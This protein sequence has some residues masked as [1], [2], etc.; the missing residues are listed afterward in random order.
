M[1]RIKNREGEINYNKQNCKMR[2]IK[3]RSAIDMDVEF[4][5]Y[6]H[7]VEHVTYSNFKKG[8]IRNNFYKTYYGV[9][10][11]GSDD[12]ITQKDGV[13]IK[14]YVC[15]TN[16]LKRCYDIN[17]QKSSSKR[18]YMGCSVDDEWHNYSLF[19][20]WWDKNYKEVEGIDF[21]LDKDILS[22]GNKV[23]SKEMC[24]FVPREINQVIQGHSKESNEPKGVRLRKGRFEARCNINGNPI[25]LGA[26]DTEEEAFQVYK[27]EKEKEIKRLADKYKDVIDR[28]VYDKLI[29]WDIDKQK[30][31]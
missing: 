14:S 17:Y 28:R 5:D 25:Y 2:I 9:G 13:S 24:V 27:L 18:A 21:Q 26:Y 29:H 30:I 3:Y 1:R 8:S 31:K 12:I 22:K 16:M 15:W 19:K 11:L 4:I 7:I 23:Y 20:D 6:G 10:Y